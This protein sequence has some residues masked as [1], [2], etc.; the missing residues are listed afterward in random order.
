MG[1]ED[2]LI[3]ALSGVLRDFG[4]FAFDL[5]RQDARRTAVLFDQWAQ[6]V[7]TGVTVAG[8]VERTSA[9]RDYPGLRKAFSSQR[10]AEQSEMGQL[11]D[12][13]REVVWTFVAGLNR[14][15]ADDAADDAQVTATLSQLAFRLGTSTPDQIRSAAAEAV[16]RVQAV[17]ESRRQRQQHQ[18]QRLAGQLD[19]LGSQLETA[20]KESTTDP[21]TQLFNRRVF[22]EELVKTS[23]F[24]ALKGAGAG[25]LIIDLDHFKQV[26]DTHGH[27]VGDAV[28][29]AI[30]S[31]C[32]RVFKQKGDV[33]ARYGG[34]ELAALVRDTSAEELA[35]LG[36]KARR[37]IAET[38]VPVGA[39][40]L[41]V[42]ASIGVAPWRAGEPTEAW[43][44]R[45]DEALYEAKH[46]GRNRVVTR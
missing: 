19:A 25:L 33:V 5:S 13:L 15:V 39:L 20:R 46:A 38:L 27:P 44:K 37:A 9:R 40:R 31:A 26:N 45:A 12:S 22:D 43:L 2:E 7:V 10:Q 29:V 36:E 16:A 3:D 17:M 1:H 24:A 11:Q 6:H 14:L 30:A 32:V 23:E 8:G 42:T 21:L 41:Q 18:L 35:T 4:R 28:L 34:E